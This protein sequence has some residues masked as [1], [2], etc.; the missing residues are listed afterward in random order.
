M[1]SL[2]VGTLLLFGMAVCVPAQEKQA[3]AAKPDRISGI[4]DMI[5]KD[6]MTITV[7]MR[8]SPTV[9]RM[10]LYDDKTVVTIEGKPGKIEEI[11]EGWSVVALGKFEGVKLRAERLNAG[12]RKN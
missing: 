10:I 9:K 3:D 7:H 1:K 8:K 2:I 5:S 11:K 4:C 6:Q 12:P